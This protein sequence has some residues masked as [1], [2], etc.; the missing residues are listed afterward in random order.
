MIKKLW[1]KW[2]PNPLDRILKKAQKRGHKK[3]LIPWNRGLGDIALGLFAIVHRI[4]TFIPDADITFVTRPDLEEGFTLL[5]GVNIKI[6]P[7]MQRKKPYVVSAEGYDLVLDNADPSH[8]VQWQRGNL[9]PKLHWNA[10]WDALC[11]RFDLPAGCIAAHVQCETGYYAE[12]D[13]PSEH[14]H[15]LFSSVNKPFV[16]LGRKKDPLYAY[17]NVIDLRGEMTLFEMLSVIKNRCYAL[18]APDSGPLSM[19][20]YLDTAFPLRVLSL[21]ADPNHGVLKQ[22]VPSPNPLLHHIPL[23]SPN[24]KNAA[25]ISPENVRE[26]LLL[27]SIE[28]QRACLVKEKQQPLVEPLIN[29]T[30]AQKGQSCDLKKWGTII[31]AGGQGT[32]LGSS[33]PKALVPITPKSLLQLFC[34]RTKAASV[35]A[36]HPLPIAIMTSPLNHEAILN[37]LEKHAYFGLPLETI[38]LFPQEMLPFLDDKGNWI[39]EEGGKIAQGPDGNGHSLKR[40]FETGIGEK[41]KNQGI[42]HIHIMPIDNALADPFDQN[43]FSAHL[44]QENEVTIKAVIRDNLQENVGALC[45]KNGKVGVWEYTELSGDTKE[46]NLANINLFCLTMSFA[47]DTAQKTLPWH[48]ARKKYKDQWI[49]KFE[50]F[51]FDMLDYAEKVGVVV[52]PRHEVYSPLKNAKGERSLQTVQAALLAQEAAL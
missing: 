22:N 44:E 14:W 23:I 40:F 45:L 31:F 13:W 21:W 43:F 8:W 35:S 6:D 49:W 25:L 50:T 51:I 1:K 27:P 3:I 19:T 28:D 52:F 47:K 24:H 11:K 17:P 38:D 30:S 34:E 48:L 42:E 36:G 16:L 9:T 20:Y 39:V 33:L 37:F 2:G 15:Q 32:R 18:I 7:S 10:A 5:G 12:R 4:R 41:W 26:A 46:L 29:Y